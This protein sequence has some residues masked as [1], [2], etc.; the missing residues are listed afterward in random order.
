M[1]ATSVASI[2]KLSAAD[3]D[4]IAVRL[5]QIAQEDQILR[6]QLKQQIDEYGFS[7]P[8]SEKSQ[9]LETEHF[10][11]TLSSSTSTAIIDTEVERIREACPEYLFAKLFS[12]MTKYKLVSGAHTLL[13]SPSLPE[14]SPRNLRQLFNRAVLVKEGTPRLRIEAKDSE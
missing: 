4:K 13:A 12:S 7:P 2:K 6:T 5:D 8:Q 10:Q 1:T 11:F 9:R 14:G 3:L